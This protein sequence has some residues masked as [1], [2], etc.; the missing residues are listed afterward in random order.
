MLQ[1]RNEL[2]LA[3]QI[4]AMLGLDDHTYTHLSHRDNNDCFFL[5]PFGLT[6]EEITSSNLL[7]INFNGQVLD[8]N[9]TIPN[10]TGYQTHASVYKARTDVQAIFHLHTPAIVA[11]SALTCGLLPISQWALHFYEK[12]TY[13]DY[14]SLI[15]ES[16]QGQ[17]LVDDLG[18]ANIML[19]RNHGVLIAAKTIQEA[20][21]Y[22]HHL[23]LACRTQC[24]T[25]A[26]QK[27]LKLPNTTTC[28]KSVETLLAFEKNLGERDWKA[29]VRRLK[30][31]QAM[32]NT[33]SLS[34]PTTA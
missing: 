20:M 19:M 31:Y 21:F 29:W 22:T 2:A 30:R 27:P 10:P 34:I 14:D 11:V 33:H 18:Q 4:L 32:Q 16:N 5:Q 13:H 28:Q 17:Q 6:F 25:L 15:T 9:E 8:G 7:R 12:I 24:Q 1:K 3:Y 26:M 23:E